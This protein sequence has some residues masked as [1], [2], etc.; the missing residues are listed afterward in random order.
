LTVGG[1][2]LLAVAHKISVVSRGAAAEEPLIRFRHWAPRTAAAA[3]VAVA[4]L[5]AAITAAIFLV[6]V[7]GWTA[8][9][10]LIGFYLTQLRHLRPDEGC[11]CFGQVAP[12]TRRA[13]VRRR[14]QALVVASAALAGLFAGGAVSSV[15]P[16]S[17]ASLAALVLVA[18]LVA[19]NVAV[20]RTQLLQT[21]RAS[22]VRE[23]T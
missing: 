23:T 16:G 9:A 2:F 22:R 6:P 7:A 17:E 14:N 1:L 3:L 15:E 19:G 18:A 20:R 4:L 12:T 11:N 8:S 13:I 5:E 10:V 21:G